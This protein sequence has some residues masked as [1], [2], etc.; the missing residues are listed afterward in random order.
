MKKLLM[1]LLV[2]SILLI[3][4]NAKA[5]T[6][7]VNNSGFENWELTTS[8][9]AEPLEWNSFKSASGTW[10][11]FGGKQLNKSIVR[12]PGTTGSFSAVIWSTTILGTTA[13]GN[14][15]TGQ[16]NMGSTSPANASNYNITRTANTAYN[17]ALGGHPDSLVVWV[18]SKISN[19]AHQ[20]RI[21]AVIHDTYDLRD[22]ADAGSTSHIVAD[23]VLNFTTAGN[24]W[25]RKS[26]PF[27]Y[28]GPATSPNYIL[29][30]FTTC[31][32]PGVGTAGDSL[33][34]DDMQLIYNPV[35]TTGTISSTTFYVS[36]TQTASVSVP[37]TLTGTMNAG[38]IVT[39]QLSNANGSFA[40]PTNIGTLP[41]TTSGTIPATI[42][43]NLPTGSGY[44]IRVISSNYALTASDNGVNLQIYN[45]GNSI[46]PIQAQSICMNGAGNTLTVTETPAGTSREWMYATTPG[47]TY[48]SFSPSQTGLT[49]TPQFNAAGNYYVICRSVIGGIAI[50]SQEVAISVATQPTSGILTPSPSAGVV[51]SGTLVSATLTP[52]TGGAGTIADILE[53]RNDAGTW[54][55]YNSGNQL[56]S[57]GLSTIDIRTYRTSSISGCATSTP[58][59]VSWTM[60]LPSGLSATNITSNSADLSWNDVNGTLWNMEYG[61]AGFQQG[62]GTLVQNIASSTYALAGLTAG[63]DYTYYVQTN[64]GSNNSSWSGPYNFSTSV[65]SQKT[66]T[67]KLFLE[68]LY[69]GTGTMNQSQN[70]IGPVFGSGIADV[71][72]VELHEETAPYNLAYAFNDIDLHTNG[73]LL[74]NS[75]AGNLIGSYYIVIKHRNSIQTWSAQPISFT[76][77]G[78]FNYDFSTAASQVYGSNQKDLQ[79]GSFAIYCGDV[80]QDDGVG[81]SDMGSVD[82]EAAIFGGGYIPEDIDGDGGVGTSDMGMIDN[83]SS[84]FIGAVIP[85]AKKKMIPLNK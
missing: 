71:V 33:Y 56:N 44:R 79:D 3:A 85:G 69:A 20:P 4:G 49:Y 32:D 25:Q 18:R 28:S 35:L 34:I 2:P 31:K 54:T 70:A 1:Q 45:V 52:G 12:R 24:V 13:N 22:P 8:E 60:A 9:F 40:S 5:Q 17:E 23:A 80:D 6:P 46:S 74:I 26:I 42:P 7:Q 10:A 82:N 62:S 37:F 41:T 64:C 72:K 36:S 27:I 21:H 30:S 38:N 19:A 50:N 14:L 73:T 77:A 58:N 63:T 11:S 83:N 67:L 75:I 55:T 57:A 43:A 78:P 15:T 84:L 68:G 61:L 53:F 81:T 39:A 65:S 76:G 51:C 66:L 48:V 47:G 59:Q 16:I 29:V